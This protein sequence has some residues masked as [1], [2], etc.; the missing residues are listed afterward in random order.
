ML[1]IYLIFPG[2][3]GVDKSIRRRR[4]LHLMEQP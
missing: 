1:M 2:T 3:F 4:A